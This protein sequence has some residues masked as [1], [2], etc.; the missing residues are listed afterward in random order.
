M[1]ARVDITKCK[2]CWG[3]VDICPECAVEK[4]V[5]NNVPIIDDDKCVECGLCA[6]ACEHG[7]MEVVKHNDHG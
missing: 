6:I 3:C 7:V 4:D 1:P 2:G 5:I